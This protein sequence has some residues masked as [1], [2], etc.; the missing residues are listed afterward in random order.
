MS[1]FEVF[2]SALVYSLIGLV[3]VKYHLWRHFTWIL[4]CPWRCHGICF[5]ELRYYRA[6]KDF[7]KDFPKSR[8]LKANIYWYDAGIVGLQFLLWLP[9]LTIFGTMLLFVT[10]IGSIGRLIMYLPSIE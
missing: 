6:G 9:L 7:D 8:Y 1:W 4:G 5:R 10:I 2:I 3:W